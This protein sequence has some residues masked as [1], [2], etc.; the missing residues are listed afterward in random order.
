M[1][2]LK[3]IDSVRGIDWGQGFLWDIKFDDFPLTEPKLPKEFSEWFPASDI[4]ENVLALE[5]HTIKSGITSFKVPVSTTPFDVKISF[6]DDINYSILNWLQEWVNLKILNEEKYLTP[7]TELVKTLHI[8][9]LNRAKEELSMSS[10]LVYP[11]G[12]LDFVGTSQPETQTYD[13]TFTIVG[14]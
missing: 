9:K 13:M 6:Y 11:E 2:F 7:L 10:Y 12:S 4:S 5:S 14:S 3:N 8:K 1:S